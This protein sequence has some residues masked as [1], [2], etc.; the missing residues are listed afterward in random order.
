MSP[1]QYLHCFLILTVQL[2]H[3]TSPIVGSS[4]HIRIVRLQ[5]T[6]T[7]TTIRAARQ[8]AKDAELSISLSV[9]SEERAGES[10]PPKAV[11]NVAR[12]TMHISI[13]SRVV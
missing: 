5:Q 11:S 8:L 7:Q 10:I 13:G 12:D 2:R 1:Q 3:S 9:S 6:C 4:P